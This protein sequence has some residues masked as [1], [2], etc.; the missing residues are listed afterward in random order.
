MIDAQ[1]IKSIRGLMQDPRWSALELA[2]KLYLK[3]NFLDGQLKRDTE[4][5]TLWFAAHS[6]GGKFH[7][8]NFFTQLENEANKLS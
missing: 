3:E 1:T 8:N 5:D 4:F 2:Y 7:I 6:E